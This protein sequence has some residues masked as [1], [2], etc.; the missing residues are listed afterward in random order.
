MKLK[1]GEWRAIA[2]NIGELINKDL[3]VL[4][5]YKL[6]LAIKKV[7]PELK[8]A[9]ETKNNLVKKYGTEKDGEYFI[10]TKNKDVFDKFMSEWN[11]V[12][13]KEAD[14]DFEPIDINELAGM[15]I[16]T[17]SMVFLSPLFKQ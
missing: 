7:D 13:E 9:E 2:E 15:K 1:I 6:S 11:K 5:A 3:P 10:D 12:I 4:T 17:A 8:V 16:S 14:F